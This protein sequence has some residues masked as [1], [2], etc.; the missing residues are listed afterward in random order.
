M[1]PADADRLVA[2]TEQGLAE[3]GDGGRSWQPIDGPQLAFVSWGAEQGLW[4]VS[5]AGETYQRVEGRWESGE[6]L[7]GE[8]QALLVTDEAL[9]A[10]V[11]GGHATAIYVS[12][13]GA[14]SWRLRYSENEA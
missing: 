1:D 4:G 3:S 9:Y 10:A 8:P 7:A 14:R 13:D 5:P 11:S 12:S 6:A 2:V